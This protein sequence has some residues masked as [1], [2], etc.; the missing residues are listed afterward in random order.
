MAFYLVLIRLLCVVC[1]QN[2]WVLFIENKLT[3]MWQIWANEF[4]Y[5]H[6]G[7][8]ELTMTKNNVLLQFDEVWELRNDYRN[9]MIN[10]TNEL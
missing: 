6:I 2:W 10:N 9:Y 5:W 4:S 8:V 7:I 1:Q 3:W